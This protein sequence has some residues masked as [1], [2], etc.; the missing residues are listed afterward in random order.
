V[1]PALR[2]RHQTGG[3]IVARDTRGLT[4]VAS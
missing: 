2:V 3:H 4:E 1:C